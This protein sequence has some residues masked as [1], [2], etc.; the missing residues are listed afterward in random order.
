MTGAIA[1][2]QQANI[3]NSSPSACVMNIKTLIASVAVFTVCTAACA[4]AW[5]NRPITL[6]IP[7]APGTAADMLGRKVGSQLSS[8]LGQPVVIENKVGA[9]GTIAYEHVAR[10]KP[11]GYTLTV[12]VGGLAIAPAI[13]KGLRFDATHDFTPIAQLALTPMIF[14][15]RPESPLHDLKDLVSAA[16]KEPDRLMYGSFGS[17]STSHLVGESFK[18]V[19]G[20]RLTHVPYKSGV[21]AVPDVVSGQLDV[22]IIDPVAAL[23]LIKAGRLKALGVAS[24]NRLSALPEVQTTAEAGV[25]FSAVGWVGL[26][27]PAGL[28]GGIASKV[29]AS[30]NSTMASLAMKEWLAGSG[31][32]TVEPA[33]SADQW[34]QRFD[35]YVQSWTLIAREAGMKVE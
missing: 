21:A 20:V 16:K 7:A 15:S 35:G 12:A 23:S 32:V 22:A 24:P 4:Q 34:R 13:Y 31:S 25:P 11:D 9:G 33:L 18:R 8:D 28:P 14:V 26:F 3:P 30:V 10:Q 2:R 29:N 17:G 5:P 27:G 1:H 6:V 19:A